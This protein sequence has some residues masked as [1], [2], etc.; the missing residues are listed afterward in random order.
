MNLQF[1]NLR[2]RMLYFLLTFAFVCQMTQLSAE[3]KKFYFDAVRGNDQNAGRSPEK[4][5][6]SIARLNND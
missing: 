6:Q 5:F 2:Y 1:I 4:A 3:T